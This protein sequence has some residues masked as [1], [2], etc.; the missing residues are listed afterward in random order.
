MNSMVDQ[1]SSEVVFLGTSGYHYPDDWKG[2]V[3]PKNLKDSEMLE[4]YTKFFYTTEIN[5]TFYT[6]PNIRSTEAWSRRPLIYSAKIPKMVTHEAKLDMSKA[7]D[8]F[9]QFMRQMYPLYE[10]EKILS[11]LL[12]LPPSFGKE[13]EKDRDR[14]E[15]FAQYWHAY[16]Q[17][18]FISKNLKVPYM[19]VEFRHKNCMNKEYFD[20]L[21]EYQLVYC[22][23][24]EPVLPPR[25][26]I[27]NEELFY[28]RFHGYGQRP[29]FN[30]EFTEK[31]LNEWAE[32]LTPIVQSAQSSANQPKKRKVAIY[33][34]NHFSGY[35]VKNAL[36]LAQ[37]MNLPHK[38]GLNSLQKPLYALNDPSAVSEDGFK[39]KKQKSLDD[40]F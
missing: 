31:E 39:G 21:H 15:L 30:Y 20:L 1:I 29:W 37:R 32:K 8:P 24:V 33:F 27:T 36:F 7:I 17:E 19:V 28:I 9:L 40:F 16:V 14:L 22:A 35:A 13:I 38:N 23:V 5:S 10:S 12:Q 11:L 6:I 3:Y 34:N 18:Q 4:Y 25:L 26:D 2:I